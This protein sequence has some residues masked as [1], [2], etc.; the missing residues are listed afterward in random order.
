MDDVVTQV[1][2]LI[3][4]HK[5]LST[6]NPLQISDDALA[7]LIAGVFI[8]KA[9]K[10]KELNVGINVTDDNYQAINELAARAFSLLGRISR[11]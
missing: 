7:I 5:R 9:V 8:S 2:A 1:R 10:D 4:L 3:D 11:P 6:E